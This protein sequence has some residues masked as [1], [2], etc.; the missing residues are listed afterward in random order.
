MR[1]SLRIANA[2]SALAVSKE[3]A[4]PSI[5]VFSDVKKALPHL[6]E[7]SEDKDCLLKNKTEKYISR[8]FPA[9]VLKGLADELGYSES[10][11]ARLIKEIYGVPFSKVVI[12]KR[13]TLAAELL[14]KKPDMPVSDVITYVGYNN[15][16][17]FRKAF[18]AKYGM[19]P[20]EYKKKGNKN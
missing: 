18:S 19:T 17:F 2:A 11:M 16:N 20:L 5:P 7:F 13:V 12:D 10:Y 8:A 14:E 4:A 3:G 9:P 15:E 6:R 1:T